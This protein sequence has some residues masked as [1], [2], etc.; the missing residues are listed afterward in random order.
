MD[1]KRELARHSIESVPS[2]QEAVVLEYNIIKEEIFVL[3]QRCDN[4]IVTM[5]TISITLLGVGLELDNENCYFLIILFLLP[6]QGLINVRRFHMARCSVYIEMCLEPK[7]QGLQWEKTVARIDLRFKRSYLKKRWIS[8]WAS[9][10]IG[11]GTILIACV[12][13]IFYFEEL[14]SKSRLSFFNICGMVIA[15][16]LFLMLCVL[17]MD[18]LQYEKIK[19][20]YKEIVQNIVKRI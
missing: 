8:K 18:Y 7:M 5:Y 16:F 12:S 6:M 20:Q 10:L 17:T 13:L 11:V 1:R 19:E 15:G 4:L 14:F 2:S 9:L 3:M